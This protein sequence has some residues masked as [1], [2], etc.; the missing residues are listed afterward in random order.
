[1][2]E[3]GEKPKYERY[4]TED[5]Q[6]LLDELANLEAIEEELG[7]NPYEPYVVAPH[8]VKREWDILIFGR[9]DNYGEWDDVYHLPQYP[10]PRY[11]NGQYRYR[12]CKECLEA[13][14]ITAYDQQVSYEDNYFARRGIYRRRTCRWC[15]QRRRNIAW[16]QKSRHRLL[17][18]LNK[19]RNNARS[20]RGALS[21][22]ARLME[23]LGYEHIEQMLRTWVEMVNDP[24]TGHR[25]RVTAYQA[26]VSLYALAESDR[27]RHMTIGPDDVDP[28]EFVEL[29]A[30]RG[31]LAPLVRACLED[32]LLTW[33][34]I[35]P[36]PFHGDGP[37]WENY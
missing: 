22:L 32:G 10:P 36:S 16:K 5:Y 4:V 15:L 20:T 28:K 17:Q 12:V 35:D 14:P 1:M 30:K 29:L 3:S 6:T 26:M 34:D 27:I 37:I 8:E 21:I 11:S 31:Q 13:L 2:S 23:D 25:Q 24:R 9:R 19:M 7:L 33:D 18:G